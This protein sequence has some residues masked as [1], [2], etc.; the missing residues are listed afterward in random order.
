MKW[1]HSV[2]QTELQITNEQIRCK[3][4]LYGKIRSERE[5]GKVPSNIVIQCL[6]QSNLTQSLPRFDLGIPEH[7]REWDGMVYTHYFQIQRI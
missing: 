7:L 5:L 6:Q 1:S 3:L 4:A 2:L